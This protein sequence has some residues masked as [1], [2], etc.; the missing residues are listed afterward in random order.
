M[1]TLESFWNDLAS[2]A[3][4][5]VGLELVGETYMSWSGLSRLSGSWTVDVAVRPELLGETDVSRTG[6]SWVGVS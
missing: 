1:R 5:V 2:A 3:V 6:L 4:I